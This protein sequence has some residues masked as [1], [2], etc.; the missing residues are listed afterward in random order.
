M[1]KRRAN[2]AQSEDV[3][4]PIDKQTVQ[5]IIKMSAETHFSPQEVVRWL[6][7]L[8]RKTMGRKITIEEGDKK[9]TISMEE[10]G[11]ITKQLDLH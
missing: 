10:F 8:G 7:W 5:E 1:P 6:T 4:V 3:L 9:L 2:K 11:K